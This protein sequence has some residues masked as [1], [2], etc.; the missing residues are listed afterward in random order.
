MFPTRLFVELIQAIQRQDRPIVAKECFMAAYS[1]NTKTTLSRSLAQKTLNFNEGQFVDHLSIINQFHKIGT[2]EYNIKNRQTFW[3]PETY[4]IHGLAPSAGPLDVGRAIRFYDPEDAKRL[5]TLMETA[6]RMKSG[7][8]A[9]LRLT[10]ADGS[11]RVVESNS[12]PVIDAEGNVARLVGTF[13]DV[14]SQTGYENLR[15]AQV[16]LLQRMVRSLPIGAAIF[17]RKLRY[18]AWSDPWLTYLGLPNDMD[19]KGR[20]HYE[21]APDLADSRKHLHELAL[22]GQVLGEDNARI[23]RA[24]GS[25]HIVDW[26]MQPWHDSKG[27]VGGIV[28]VTNLRYLG[29]PKLED[30][31]SLDE[32]KT[33]L[34]ALSDLAKQS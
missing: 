30:A 23:V 5:A 15:L 18:I 8:Q 19:L 28:A 7:F 16:D 21:V 9:V 3:S 6:V 11:M 26:R 24:N 2:W 33:A 10:R 22:K 29:A 32:Q 27:D 14:T 4:E 31:L 25:V 34:N 17:D 12:A 1:R 20:S 13:R